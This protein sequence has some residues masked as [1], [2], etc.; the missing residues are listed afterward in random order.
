MIEGLFTS[1]SMPA[2]EKLVDFTGRRHRH[3]ANNIANLSTPGYQP[4]DLSVDDFQAKL[5]KAIDARR[6]RNGGPRGE[7]DMK[8][9]EPTNLHDNIMFHD[10]NNRSLEHTM[11]A[12]AEN[13]MAHNAALDLMRNQFSMLEST[14]REQA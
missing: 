10:R 2:L 1:G 12:L 4:T 14:I 5:G 8:S 9:L 11:Q 6:T 7:L 3:L 13:T